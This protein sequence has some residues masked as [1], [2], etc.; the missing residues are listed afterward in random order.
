LSGSLENAFKLA[1]SFA[2]EQ[3]R[4]VQL[5]AERE[6]L[7][8]ASGT[9]GGHM[10]K[11]HATRLMRSGEV[12]LWRDGAMVWRGAVGAHLTGVIF[13]AVSLHVDDG[14]TMLAVPWRQQTCSSP[15]PSG[16]HERRI[17]W[18]PLALTLV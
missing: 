18:A 6:D 11:L 17:D 1:R 13:D 5:G 16:G 12:A 8:V 9:P 14:Q 2:A 15:L 10:I 4:I 7:R 3:M